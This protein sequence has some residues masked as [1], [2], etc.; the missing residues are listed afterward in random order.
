M[1]SREVVHEKS[2]ENQQIAHAVQSHVQG[3]KLIPEPGWMPLTDTIIG[4]V[5]I[6]GSFILILGTFINHVNK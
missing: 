5:V 4:G 3:S 6:D 1:P 2:Q